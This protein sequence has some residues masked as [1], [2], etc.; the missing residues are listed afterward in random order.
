M[1]LCPFSILPLYYFPKGQRKQ[2]RTPLE[3][4]G[5][6]PLYILIP[7]IQPVLFSLSSMQGDQEDEA[8][9]VEHTHF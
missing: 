8:G 2:T 9:F 5:S 4:Q 6:L 3:E 7:Q 1:C